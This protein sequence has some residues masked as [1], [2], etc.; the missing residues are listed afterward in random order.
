MKEIEHHIGNTKITLLAGKAIFLEKKGVLVVSDIH[1]GKAAHFRKHGIPI[2]KNIHENDLALLSQLLKATNAKQLLI[3][4]DLFH[5]ELNGEWILFKDFVDKH[6][7][8]K[9]TLVA[10]NHDRYT[11]NHFKEI[12][13]VCDSQLLIQNI[14]FTHEPLEINHIDDSLYN[15]CGHIHPAVVLRGNGRQRMKLPC[16]YFG[17][18]QGILPAFGKF[19]GAAIIE[20]KAHDNVYVVANDKVIKVS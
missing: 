10:G 12:L 9:M 1:L 15:I 16:F 18:K 14:L 17:E 20:P 19:T 5:S 6:I 7:N 13:E 4:G 8:V 3:I 11:K 2:S